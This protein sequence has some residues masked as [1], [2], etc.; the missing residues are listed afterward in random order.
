MS[1]VDGTWW[2]QVLKGWT[3]GLA[4]DTD[5]MFYSPLTLTRWNCVRDVI[6][7]WIYYILTLDDWAFSG[8]PFLH[9]LNLTVRGGP[10]LKFSLGVWFGETFYP[11]S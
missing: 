6:L 4:A 9:Y 3:N 2:R 10:S 8:L 11:I 5:V 1:C 7:I